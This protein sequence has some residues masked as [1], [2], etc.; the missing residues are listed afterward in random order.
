VIL[1]RTNLGTAVAHGR[2]AYVLDRADAAG[3]ADAVRALRSDA[4]LAARLARGAIE[5]ADSHF[6]W[7]RSAA[8]LE[9]FYRSIASQ[10][11]R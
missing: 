8:Q 9:G 1:P 6:S 10:V 2:D 3:I 7:S 5:F 4:E 11:A